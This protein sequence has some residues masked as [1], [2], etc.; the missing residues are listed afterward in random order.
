VRRVGL[1]EL[2][3]GPAPISSNIPTPMIMVMSATLPGS[4]RCHRHASSNRAVSDTLPKLI[5]RGPAWVK[6]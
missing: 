4:Q 1:P 6:S 5:G 3:F 2:A